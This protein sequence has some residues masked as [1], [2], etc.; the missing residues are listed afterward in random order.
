MGVGTSS[1]HR[2][3]CLSSCSAWLLWPQGPLPLR[4]LAPCPASLE[5]RRRP[6]T[7]SRGKCLSNTWTSSLTTTTPVG[8]PLLTALTLPALLTVSMDAARLSSRLLLEPTTSTPSCLRTP[9]RA[10]TSRTCGGTRLTTTPSSPTTCPFWN[11]TSPLSSMSLSSPCRSP[12]WETI[13]QEELS[14]LTQAGALPVTPS[15]L[16]CPTI[17]SLWKCPS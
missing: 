6:P 15:P 3:R 16:P 13:L 17:S 14:V 9:S 1:S 4:T 2:P 12:L 7:S 8:P 10:D 5:A 11:W